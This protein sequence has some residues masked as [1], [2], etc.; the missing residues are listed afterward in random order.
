MPFGRGDRRSNIFRLGVR[1]SVYLHR[2][3]VYRIRNPES[4]EIITNGIF[5]TDGSP[6]LVA[7][8]SRGYLCEPQTPQKVELLV[9]TVRKL[10]ECWDGRA[11]SSRDE[12][13]ILL[14][15]LSVD[16]EKW[17]SASIDECRRGI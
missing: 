7:F 4:T 2:F 10:T 16:I 14:S 17:M 15:I 6:S 8:L 13:L 1:F 12:R 11:K 9:R 3:I 5:Q